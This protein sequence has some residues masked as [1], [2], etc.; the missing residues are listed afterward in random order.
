M[1]SDSHRKE[2]DKAMKIRH[3]FVPADYWPEYSKNK[4]CLANHEGLGFNDIWEMAQE[5]WPGITAKELR[6]EAEHI[7]THCLG[8]DQYDPSDYTNFVVIIASDEY[9]KRI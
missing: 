2:E 8:F 1:T 6:L 3:G 5:R 4:L 7:Q 9:F